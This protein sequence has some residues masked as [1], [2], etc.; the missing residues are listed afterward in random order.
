MSSPSAYLI[1]RDV[2]ARYGMKGLEVV[3][4]SDRSRSSC[5]SHQRSTFPPIKH[6]CALDD[7]D[8]EVV[9]VFNS[10][11]R[12]GIVTRI[13]ETLPHTNW[14]LNVLRLGFALETLSNPITIHLTLAEDAFARDDESAAGKIVSD[15]LD[16]VQGSQMLLA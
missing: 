1:P 14:R 16:L 8:D 10:Q 15:I 3:A 9:R 6:V 13:Q 5:L 2:R 4:S 7:G 11:L 12:D